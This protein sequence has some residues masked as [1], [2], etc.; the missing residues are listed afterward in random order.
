MRVLHAFEPD[1]RAVGPAVGVRGAV[2]DRVDVGQAGAAELVDVDPVGARRAGR[3]Q[4][5]DGGHDADADDDHVAGDRLAARQP[6]AG[7]PAVLALERLDLGLQPQVD[8][9]RAV[10]GLV[11]RATGPR[12]RRAPARAASASSRVTWQPSLV[13]TAAASSPI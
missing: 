5:A 8:A 11:E 4:R 12:P 9:V 6:H 1:H 2:A 10:L 3:D 13:S 7:G